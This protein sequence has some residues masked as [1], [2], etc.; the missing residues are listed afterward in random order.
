MFVLYQNKKASFLFGIFFWHLLWGHTKPTLAALP[1]LNCSSSYLINQIGAGANSPLFK[2]GSGW[3]FCWSPANGYGYSVN[4]VRY[5]S[6]QPKTIEILKSMNVAQMFVPYDNNQARYHDIGYGTKLAKLKSTDCPLGTLSKDQTLCITVESRG[7]SAHTTTT[8]TTLPTSGERLRIFGYY[9]IGAYYYTFQY[10]FNDDGSI[11]PSMGASGSLQL[12]SEDKT[13]GWPVTKTT[14]TNPYGVNHNHLIIWRL[15]FSIDD[16]TAVS[17]VPPTSV[18]QV[19][20]QQSGTTPL[21]PTT[22]LLT[23]ETSV[24]NNLSTQRYWL[25]KNTSLAASFALE[26]SVATQYRATTENFTQ[27]DF[28]LSQYK[29]SE[30]LVDG[31]LTTTYLNKET[32]TDPVVWYGVNFHHVP[33]EEDAV[34]MPQHWQGFTIRPLPLP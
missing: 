24:R 3:S 6:A 10:V 1:T 13:T 33:R 26:Q 7:L 17:A 14:N 29:S 8:S 5:T 16:G 4:Q 32:V 15:H 11:E 22:Q 25:V 30:L 23:A 12:T 31:G 34:R 28:Y 9:G 19:D 2:N 18:E 21:A 27:N 20:F